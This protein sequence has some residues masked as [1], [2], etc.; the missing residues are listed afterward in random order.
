MQAREDEGDDVRGV[1]KNAQFGVERHEMISIVVEEGG[2]VDPAS[3]QRLGTGRGH[4]ERNELDLRFC[5][6]DAL[7]GEGDP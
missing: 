4:A 2:A 3:Q 6:V 1:D 5:E 7:S